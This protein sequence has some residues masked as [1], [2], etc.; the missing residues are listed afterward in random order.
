MKLTIA[1]LFPDLLNLYGDAGNIASLKHR[2]L[3]RD[4]EVEVKEYNNPQDIDFDNNDIIYIGGGTET[5]VILVNEQLKTVK[6][7]LKNYIENN[8]CV[9]A[10]CGG[11][12]MLGKYFM[13][14][15]EKIEGLSVLDI[16]TEYSKN[17]LIG[18]VIIK[19]SIA[20]KEIVGFEN[21]NGITDI[22]NLQHLGEVLYG[23]GSSEGIIYKNVIGTYLHGPILPKNP[24]LADY[25]LNK[26]LTRK[27]DTFSLKPL[28]D[29]IE[30]KANQYIVNRFI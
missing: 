2:A 14:G 29:S 18:N 4:I 25:I 11:Y 22:G 3:W 17:R 12:Q 21:R 1:H 13:F 15:D 6:D 20:D 30:L 23:K 27:D 5:A 10:V 19:S 28:D 7:D 24:H 8:G 16:T 9:L 26:A